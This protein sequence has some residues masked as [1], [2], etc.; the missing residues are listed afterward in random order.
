MM[1]VMLST[2]P[3]SE[4]MVQST[5]QPSTGILYLGS[6]LQKQAKFGFGKAADVKLIDAG[7]DRME[8]ARAIKQFQPDVF[9]FTCYEMILDET[10]DFCRFIN[11]VSPDTRIFL[12]GATP[13]MVP[14]FVL[15]Y[16]GANAVLRGEADFTLRLAIEGLAQGKKL[17]SLD[18]P[19]L[20]SRDGSRII[21]TASSS[22][23]PFISREDYLRIDPIIDL[24]YGT[25]YRAMGFGFSRGCPNYRC[26]FC[27]ITPS[28][29]YRRLETDSVVRILREIS[30]IPGVEW[31][32]FNDALFGGGKAGAK[33]IMSRL[34]KENFSFKDGFSAQMSVDMLLAN[35]EFGQRE[36]DIEMLKMM[37]RLK[38]GCDIGIESLSESLLVKFNK[39]RYTYNEIKRLIRAM[40]QE[41]VDGEGA[42]MLSSV[43]SVCEETIENVRRSFEVAGEFGYAPLSVIQYAIP[44][45]G[46][47]EYS[48]YMNAESKAKDIPEFMAIRNGK[49]LMSLMA[50]E[51]MNKDYPVIL[52]GAIPLRDPIYQAAW[53]MIALNGHSI[54][55]E[56]AE[57]LNGPRLFSTV[58]RPA[59]HLIRELAAME[60]AAFAFNGERAD[61]VKKMAADALMFIEQMSHELSG[62]VSSIRAEFA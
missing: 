5:P 51:T 38:M 22:Q 52:D 49:Y 43:D 40:K 54:E 55:Q 36:A 41:S 28:T 10:R 37:N 32:V 62:I 13:T 39:F 21:T 48:K 25:G 34:E 9:G 26:S 12:G 8:L 18:I 16:T 42:V 46:T 24:L 6:M 11:L 31:M 33:E 4:R 20:V 53:K 58:G 3:A 56:L 17:E 57:I 29:N 19:G 50:T 15:K 61:N 23:I 35:G 30:R 7:M 47:E 2:A 44:Y 1:K 59:A 14:D 60:K 45:M 27:I